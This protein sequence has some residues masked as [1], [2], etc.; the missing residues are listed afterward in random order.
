MTSR[1]RA[2]YAAAALAFLWASPALADTQ[3]HAD[4]ASSELAATERELSSI[5]QVVAKAQG[6]ALSVQERLANGEILYR[7]K[8]YPRATVVLSE[9]IEKYPDSDFRAAAVWLRGEAYYE[10]REYLAAKRDYKTLVERQSDERYK[11]YFPKALARLVD[12]SLRINDMQ[13]VDDVLVRLNA[14][15]PS[16]DP[17]VLYA[18]GK[19]LFAKKDYT[20]DASFAH[21]PSGSAYTHQARY[22]QALIA[23]RH[24]RQAA[25]GSAD[26][27]SMQSAVPSG[28]TQPSKVAHTVHYKEAL[29]GFR[30]VTQLP[31]DTAEHQHV[32]D[33][34]WMAIGRIFYELEQYSQAANAYG[35]VGRT[36]PEFDTM[37]YELAWVYVRLGDLTRAQYALE[38]LSVEN[39][40][41][42]F[43]ADGTLLRADL[44]LRAG[45]YNDA[46]KL[47]QSVRDRYAPLRDNVENFIDATKDVAVYYDRLSQRDLDTLEDKGGL[48]PLAVKWARE[49]EGGTLV[50]AI[51]DDVAMCRS[52]IKQSRS[53]IERLYA[54]TN[55]ANRVRLFP[56]LMAGEM[57]AVG[58][59]NRVAKA[60]LEIAQG[61]D[62]AEPGE[63][64]GELA[65]VR[66]RRRQLMGTV[67]QMPINMADFDA[68]EQAG[69][70]R[71]NHVSQGLSQRVLEIDYLQALI[72]GLRTWMRRD[73][74]R[75]VVRDPA[76]T[77]RFQKELEENE[78][79]LK[80]YRENATQLRN[81]LEVGRIQVGFGDSRYQDDASKRMEFRELVEREVSLV[82][83]GQAG[84]G[85]QSFGSRVSPQVTQAR[86][87][88]DRLIASFN[89]L[90][91][92]VAVKT[93]ELRGKV[94]E[95]RNNITKYNAVLETYDGEARDLVGRVARRN[96]II[97]RDKLRNIVL[98]ADV[99]ITE[100]AWE[101]REEELSRVRSLQTER[102]REEQLLDEELK[103]VLDDAGEAAPATGTGR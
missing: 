3:A 52:L 40:D 72:N 93:A 34:S 95:E 24:A 28:T 45:A 49:A 70:E 82:S 19:A 21:I 47:Y 75:G 6:S 11:G 31:A 78:T 8:D 59:L 26:A 83:S 74:Q 55:A 44:L 80:G 14:M 36:S 90:E 35:R 79:I 23:M 10:S 101:L 4:N 5:D 60:R 15:P 33:L 89:A 39:P 64:A 51:L 13:A 91:G 43:Q 71:W 9:I 68:R 50:F 18:R 63:V 62:E 85:A 38:I 98:R 54:V 22:F 29:D 56:E 58:L 81:Q 66:A 57:R 94:D 48:S 87:L 92:K 46:L 96:F 53:L 25:L 69:V 17:V 41:S 86:S 97:V 12:V 37:L 76:T 32:I 16:S 73:P 77:A 100:Q 103:E 7:T 42:E 67:A 61:L 88:E 102:A 30:A 99:G 1:R 27:P 2:G 84:G 65:S 20:A